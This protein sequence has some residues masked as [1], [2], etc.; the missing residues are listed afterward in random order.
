MPVLILIAVF[1]ILVGVYAFIK[2]KNSPKFDCAVKK[3]TEEQ[4]MAE[5]KT[6]EVIKKIGAAETAL[7]NKAKRQEKEI[8][9]TQED[10]KQIEDYL[11]KEKG[12]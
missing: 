2:F 7:G 12:E 4:P 11:K 6:G 1:V 10:N 5:P 9:K 8:K 3:M